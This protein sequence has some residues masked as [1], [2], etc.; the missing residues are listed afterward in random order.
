M[1]EL[2]LHERISA[3]GGH[4]PV[5]GRPRPL[6]RENKRAGRHTRPFDRAGAPAVNSGVFELVS[7][8]APAGD[9]PQAI[10]K[11]TAGLL[12]G[13]GHQVL[14][15]VTGS[16]KTFTVA[17]VIKN[18]NRPT[19]VISHNKTLAAQLYAEF[20]SFFPNNAVE[21]FVSYF[22]Y[23]QPEAYIPRTDTFIE[24]DSSRNDEIERLRLSTMSSLFTRRDVVVVASVSCIYGIGS[25]EDYEAL[26]IP[27]RVGQ[28][29]SREQFLSRLVGLQYDRNDIAFERGNFRVRGDTVEVW[30]A[31]REDGLRLEFFGDEI[32]KLT[33]FEPLTGTKIE[34]LE[35]AMVF[36]ARQFVTTGDKMK[37]ALLAIREELGVRIAEFERDG[38]LLEAQRIKQRTE[39]DLEMMEEMGVCSGIE[40]YS[41]HISNRP[42]GS[43]PATL[44]DFFPD[45]YLLVID[46]SHVTVPQVGGM[47]E[48]DRSRKTVLVNYGFRLPSALDNRPLNFLEFQGLQNQTIYVSATPAQREIEW[49]RQSA[50][51]PPARPAL[52]GAPVD[53][54]GAEP[55]PRPGVVELVVRPTGL[56]DPRVTVKPLKGQIDDLIEE[57]RKRTELKE[58]T[59]V[60]TLTKRTA[61][62]LTDYLRDIGVNVRYLHSEI[63]AI[64]RVE[65]LRALRKG[66]FNVL[67]GINLLREGLDLPEVSLVAILDADKEGFL[68]SET[69]LIQTAGRAARHLNGEVILYADVMTD[70]IKKFLAVTE[71][72]RQRQLEYNR[73]HHITPRSVIRAVEDSLAVYESSRAQA[74][75]LL[76]DARLDVDLTATIA[77]LE[78]EMMKAA[79]E[80][81]FEKAALLRDQI[82]EL[83][84]MLEGAP[85]ESKGKPV[86]Y[87]RSAKSAGKSGRARAGGRRAGTP[88]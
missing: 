86:S 56:V 38:K 36:P 6:G 8:Y 77:E 19:L 54:A 24:K 7:D 39:F 5:R 3:G 75:G 32:E 83:K 11:L 48:G 37:R 79:E 1:R 84:R 78:T 27:L 28:A 62:E 30:P 15:G 73:V 21:Y 52:N 33:R 45:D 16:G 50:G 57:V 2:V 74:A 55:G 61:E 88:S 76:K 82:K 60:T 49:A 18:V 59:L 26:V 22:D 42:P 20:K 85:A 63:D 29:T 35:A 47:F 80:L 70:S 14:L 31:G 68:R 71:R 53:P 69:S 44:F 25:K 9:Q 13:A 65:I 34:S 87:H 43:R 51:A 10:E 12:G 64:E 17:N 67:V 72:R 58:R 81:A 4:G 40:N 66:E 41:R 23:Y 46:E